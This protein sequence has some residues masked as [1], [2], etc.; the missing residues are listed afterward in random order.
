LSYILDSDAINGAID[1]RAQWAWSNV[2]TATFDPSGTLGFGPL[3]FNNNRNGGY[4]QASYRP[5]KLL[6]SFWKDVE[7]IVRYDAL[8]QPSGAPTSFDENRVTLGLDYW[9]SPSSVAKIAYRID[10]KNGTWA[11]EDAFFVQMAF[12]F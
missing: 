4:V 1:L 2:N 8:N 7:G 5:S 9:M 3:K 6:N 11:D 12:G 10:N